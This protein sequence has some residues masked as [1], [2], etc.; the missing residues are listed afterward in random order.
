MLW[1]SRV[2]GDR[3]SGVSGATS[4]KRQEEVRGRALLTFPFP[5]A[6]NYSRS[7]PKYSDRIAIIATLGYL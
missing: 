2:T 7:L 6:I 1:V 5:G 4:D 3:S